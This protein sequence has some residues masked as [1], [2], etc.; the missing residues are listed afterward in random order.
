M[1]RQQSKLCHNNNQPKHSPTKLAKQEKSN[2]KKHS[3]II[4][5]PYDSLTLADSNLGS[6]E[7][8]EEEEEPTEAEQEGKSERSRS[9]F[10][11]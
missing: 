6:L 9:S 10:R 5:S 3:E 11:S 1:V 7:P 4:I 2:K 8:E